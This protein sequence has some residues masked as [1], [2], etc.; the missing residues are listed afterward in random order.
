[1]GDEAYDE[2]AEM[3]TEFFHKHLRRVPARRPAP[4]RAHHHRVLL[5][6]GQVDDYQSLIATSYLAPDRA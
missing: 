2:G 4:P 1:V 5:D 3:L 6:H